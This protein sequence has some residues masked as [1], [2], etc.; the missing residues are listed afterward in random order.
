MVGK[1]ST[2]CKTN[3]AYFKLFYNNGTCINL[4]EMAQ[5]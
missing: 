1:F 3:K 5:K 2:F 4:H